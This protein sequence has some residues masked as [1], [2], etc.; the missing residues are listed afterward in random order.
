MHGR[1]CQHPHRCCGA[2]SA[3]KRP[4]YFAMDGRTALTQQEM[5]ELNFGEVAL[6]A[7]TPIG[8]I[9]P[10]ALNRG[11]LGLVPARSSTSNINTVYLRE[12]GRSVVTGN[13]SNFFQKNS[14]HASKRRT[15]FTR[16]ILE[17]YC[18]TQCRTNSTISARRTRTARVMA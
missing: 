1:P 12:R 6:I 18:F 15:I 8:I 17:W 16:G 4:W 13:V 2:T 5:N 10:I 14:R 7:L 3:L 9:T 11:G